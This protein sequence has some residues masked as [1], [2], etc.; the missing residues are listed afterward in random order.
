[1]ASSFGSRISASAMFAM[2]AVVLGSNGAAHAFVRHGNTIHN[3]HHHHHRIIHLREC[4]RQQRHGMLSTTTTPT[5]KSSTTTTT[6]NE[7]TELI[8]AMAAVAA[9]T[10]DTNQPQSKSKST[11]VPVAAEPSSPS[12]TQTTLTTWKDDGFVFGLAGSGLERSAGPAVAKLVV[13]GDSLETR[14]HQVAVVAATFGAHAYFATSAL[15]QMMTIA[16]VSSGA[17]ATTTAAAAMG[18]ATAA[19]T[20]G[21]TAVYAVALALAAWIVADFGSGVLHWSVDNYGNGRTPIMGPI[22]AAFQ[23]HH[24]APWTITYRGFCNNVYKLCTPFGILPML[25]VHTLCTPTAPAVTWFMAWFCAFEVASQEFH[26]WSHQRPSASPWYANALQTAGLAVSRKFH[27]QHHLAPYEGNYCIISGLC[28]NVLD[29][30]GF[31]RRLEHAVYRWNGVEANAWKLDPALRHRIMA[32]DYRLV[33][34]TPSSASSSSQS[35]PLSP[36]YYS[37]ED[38]TTDL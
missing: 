7:P 8:D 12:S 37:N 35:S 18:G 15:S 4:R 16:A 33:K 22:I 23:G 14:P 5:S 9:T 26:K 6:P 21:V 29:R 36:S 10:Q 1:M 13:D 25:V 11:A 2:A 19:A 24:S 30:T 28:N 32:G 20:L 34:A 31:F 38:N 3:H 17:A 27:A